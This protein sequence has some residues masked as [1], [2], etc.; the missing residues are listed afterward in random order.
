MAD[1]LTHVLVGYIIGVLLSFK[2]RWITP[3]MVTVVM[4]G[5]LSPDFV[6]IN[7]VLSDAFVEALLGVP[8]SWSPLHRLGGNA[9]VILAGSMLV[10]PEYRRRVLALLA[11]GALS[12]HLLDVLLLTQSG[13]T[14]AVFWPLTAYHPPA[15]NLYLSS[16]RWPAIVAG[17]GAVL[18]WFL[19]YSTIG[20]S[21]QD[22]PVRR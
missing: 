10:A 12:H 17:A 11:I 16:D 14:Y 9:L 5:A 13:Y 3:P 19:R 15:P 7:L 18:V 6:K 1:V 21:T 4:I 20:G 22:R 8:F 2:Y